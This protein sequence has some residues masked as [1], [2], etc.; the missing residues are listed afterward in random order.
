MKSFPNTQSFYSVT[1]CWQ[2]IGI[3]QGSRDFSRGSYNS[4]NIE[5]NLAK[6]FCNFKGLEV[7]VAPCYDV[8]RLL[9]TCSW[10]VPDLIIEELNAGQ[11]N[12]LKGQLVP[13][14]F[15]Q[16]IATEAYNVFKRLEKEVACWSKQDMRYSQENKCCCRNREVISL[17]VLAPSWKRLSTGTIWQSHES[18]H[19][20]GKYWWF[21][22]STGSL[23]TM[24]FGTAAVAHGFQEEGS[25]PPPSTSNR[26]TAPRQRPEGR[27]KGQ[28]KEGA[29]SGTPDNGELPRMPQTVFSCH[30]LWP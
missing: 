30:A 2:E 8:M 12:S 3:F 20:H 21:T 22:G 27:K 4:V 19:Q 9:R 11:Q 5:N 15:V 7:S 13:I 16:S 1:F 14:C 18:E 6:C 26:W 25:M 23:P 29:L 24:A 28:G 10:T 17:S